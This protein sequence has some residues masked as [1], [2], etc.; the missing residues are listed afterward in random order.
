M[1]IT[2]Q[3]AFYVGGVDGFLS[4]KFWKGGKAWTLG[5]AA[6]VCIIVIIIVVAA[7][8]TPAPGSSPSPWDTPTLRPTWTGCTDTPDWVD[9]SGNGCDFYESLPSWCN[10]NSI[11]EGPMGPATENC[12]VCG[13]GD[14]TS[15]TSKAPAISNTP[16]V[17]PSPPTPVVAVPTLASKDKMASNLSNTNPFRSPTAAKED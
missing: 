3:E 9:R 6:C 1:A 12:C 2:E 14:V 4:Y 5:I 7:T 11:F 16:S 17:A 10:M 13:G 15:N 8:S